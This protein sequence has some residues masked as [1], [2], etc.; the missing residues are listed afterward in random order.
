MG[1]GQGLVGRPGARV[2]QEQGR[3]ARSG[4]GMDRARVEGASRAVHRLEEASFG[5]CG[6]GQSHI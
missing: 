1:R 6:P 5:C 3:Q 2:D 4:E